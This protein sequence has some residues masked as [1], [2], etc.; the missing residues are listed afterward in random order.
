VDELS[1]AYRIRDVKERARALRGR[2][3][4]RDRGSGSAGGALHCKVAPDR[5]S[6]AASEGLHSTLFQPRGR[7]G[8]SAGGVAEETPGTAGTVCLPGLTRL[9][10]PDRRGRRSLATR[11]GRS[12]TRPPAARDGGECKGEEGPCQGLSSYLSGWHH[13]GVHVVMCRQAGDTAG[14]A[15]T[16]IEITP[17]MV[18]AGTRYL[19]DTEDFGSAPAYLAE[20]VFRVMLAA[21]GSR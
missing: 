19:L 17:Q 20:E 16:E 8:R 15:E 12:G 6:Q 4:R 18:E 11:S 1:V 9:A 7:S 21:R 3:S 13:K 5:R 10:G 14:S 2:L